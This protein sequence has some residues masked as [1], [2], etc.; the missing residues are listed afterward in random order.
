MMAA[1]S[2]SWSQRW[3]RGKVQPLLGRAHI[4][5]AWIAA[6]LFARDRP[7]SEGRR[8]LAPACFRLVRARRGHDRYLH[9]TSALLTEIIDY[10]HRGSVSD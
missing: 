9:C 5:F 10:P 4:F 7:C 6:T 8:Y 1:M 2:P 3:A